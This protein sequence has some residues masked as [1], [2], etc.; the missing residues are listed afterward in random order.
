MPS[1][2][3]EREKA[4][5][6][7][8]VTRPQPPRDPHP[9]VQRCFAQNVRCWHQHP[10]RGPAPPLPPPAVVAH[11]R[12]RSGGGPGHMVPPVTWSTHVPCVQN[13]GRKPVRPVPTW[14]K[15]Y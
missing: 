13:T 3:R 15:S 11:R 7:S 9:T 5:R 6:A 12:Q 10:R 8:R 4:V 14:S 2:E 1:R